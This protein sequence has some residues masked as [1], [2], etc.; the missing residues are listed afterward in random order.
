[1]E[2]TALSSFVVMTVKQLLCLNVKP[3]NLFTHS[4]PPPCDL[5]K[6]LMCV[7]TLDFAGSRDFLDLK[8]M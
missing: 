5:F 6:N 2:T 3:L 7:G 1:M 4:P 8:R